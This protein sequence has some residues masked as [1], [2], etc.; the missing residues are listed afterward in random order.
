MMSWDWNRFKT[1]FDSDT[2][3]L[4]I[5]R[6]AVGQTPGELVTNLLL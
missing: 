2:R 1:L 4:T 6:V 3:R 5:L